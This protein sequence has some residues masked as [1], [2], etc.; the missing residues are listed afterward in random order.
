LEDGT[1]FLYEKTRGWFDE[2]RN[3]YNK[4]GQPSDPPS[5]LLSSFVEENDEDYDD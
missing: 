2:Y 4:E 3:Y 1:E 5:S